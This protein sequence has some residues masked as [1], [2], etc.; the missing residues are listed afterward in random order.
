MYLQRIVDKTRVI[1]LKSAFILI[2]CGQKAMEHFLMIIMPTVKIVSKFCNQN[3]LIL[4]LND[5]T[6]F[7]WNS[8]RS[9]VREM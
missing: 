5:I 4:C 9:N 6:K 3:S 7:K 8:V 1:F 2:I